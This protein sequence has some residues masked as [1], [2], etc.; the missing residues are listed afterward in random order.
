VNR[1]DLGMTRTRSLLGSPLYMAPEQVKSSRQ[2]DPRSDIWSIGV[3]L[4]ELVTGQPRFLGEELPEIVLNI[5]S[6]E[7]L[8]LASLGP[9]APPSLEIVIRRCLEKDPE[10]RFE[11]LAELARA[12]SDLAP[13][14]ARPSVARIERMGA[15]P[16]IPPSEVSSPR[17]IEEAATVG[18]ARPA[19]REARTFDGHTS[20][21]G[22]ARSPFPAKAVLAVGFVLLVAALGFVL[23]SNRPVHPPSSVAVSS[24]PTPSETP[25]TSET[26][27]ER[28]PPPSPSASG[29]GPAGEVTSTPPATASGIPSS[30]APA[31]RRPSPRGTATPIPASAKP[32]CTFPYYVDAQG[33]NSTEP[34]AW[35]ESF[36]SR[37]FPGPSHAGPRGVLI[38]LDRAGGRQAGLSRRRFEGS[39]PSR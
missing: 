25:A 2:A 33:T 31:T 13:A 39:G 12:L 38:R 21:Q 32:D 36:A 29:T 37:S 1:P 17:S 24:T 23:F 19:A 27:D 9:D 22:A 15:P 4:F 18:L 26:P 3:I 7:P 28:R 16:R 30:S 34:S 11:N 8:A 5:A 20:A 35:N 14:S 6:A 10:R